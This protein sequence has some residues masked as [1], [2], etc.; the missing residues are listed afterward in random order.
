[1]LEKVLKFKKPIVQFIPDV[2]A[3]LGILEGWDNKFSLVHSFLNVFAP[4]IPL[5]NGK[6]T[7]DVKIYYS[8]PG[9]TEK[10]I[11]KV[12]IRDI[13]EFLEESIEKDYY[14]M[15]N[16]DSCKI[17]AYNRDNSQSCFPHPLFVFGMNQE[18]KY[19]LCAD[20]FD[21]H[22]YGYALVT[23]EEME[24][25]HNSIFESSEYVNLE[26]GGVEWITDVVL[27]RYHATYKEDINMNRI[28]IGLRQFL[29]SENIFGYSKCTYYR[30]HL[31]AP[32]RGT[33]SKYLYEL[34]GNKEYYGL[35]VFKEILNS[36]RDIEKGIDNREIYNKVPYIMYAYHELML[37]V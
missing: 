25:A 17:A 11:P 20:F 31:M 12:M 21:G 24:K 33:D 8:V 29:N 37:H 15:I 10:R 26:S 18:K 1:M 28:V 9:I 27:L 16:V 3:R 36:Y 14:I 34:E 6:K 35:A 23:Y 22:N 4:E 7:I 5:S 2:A 19:F 30:P 13:V 32:D